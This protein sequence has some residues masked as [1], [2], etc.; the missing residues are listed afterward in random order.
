M[1]R[2]H[3]TIRNRQYR[4]AAHY[5][6]THLRR[7]AF[8]SLPSAHLDILCDPPFSLPK[9]FDAVDDAI[10]S[11]AD[12]AESMLRVGLAAFGVDPLDESW[13]GKAT[14][15]D[16]DKARSTLRQLYRDWSAEGA[17]ERAASYVPILDALRD[18]L[19][20]PRGSDR[21]SQRVL[22][23]GAGL[24][25]LVLEICSDGY[26]V[27]GNEVSYHQLIASN[28]I[29]NH[30]AAAR[31]HALYPWALSFSNHH[32]RANQL[33]HVL[34]PDVHPATALEDSPLTL[35]PV[36]GPVHACQ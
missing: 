31:Q 32:N 26:C 3:H 20:P 24:G 5:N 11:N 21:S 16:L 7:Q 27:E 36:F 13:K 33:Q 6:I 22:V 35:Y 25:R 28:Y 9:T 23:P 2:S 34:I 10:D 4:Q 12:I 30:A 29:L 15:N 14:P 18:H 8:Y 1:A 17:A 19:P